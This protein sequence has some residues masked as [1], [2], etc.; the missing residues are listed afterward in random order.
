[1]NRIGLPL[2]SRLRPPPNCEHAQADQ[3]EQQNAGEQ[4]D[5][6]HV[7]AHV[8]VEDVAELVPDHALQFVAVE[9]V[10]RPAGHRDRGVGWAC[11]RP[12]TR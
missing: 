12:R 10:Q 3:A 5:Q 2:L 11:S 7:D 1:M 6:P 9:L 4:A 8:A